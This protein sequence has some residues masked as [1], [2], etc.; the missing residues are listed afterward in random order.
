MSF[1]GKY[2]RGDRKREKYKT[3]K[4]RKKKKVKG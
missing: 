1:G 3:K 2:K 4:T